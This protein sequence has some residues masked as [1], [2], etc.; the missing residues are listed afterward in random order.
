[1]DI[2]AI[3]RDKLHAAIVTIPQQP[4]LVAG[5]VRENLL[6]GSLCPST[7]ETIVSILEKLQI[8]AQTHEHRGL[9][10]S[11]GSVPLTESQRQLVCIGRALLQ[12][13]GYCHLGRGDERL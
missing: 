5:T 13:G 2:A 7:D 6:L 12:P 8:W 1:M 9:D 3:P 10:A 4:L 11:I